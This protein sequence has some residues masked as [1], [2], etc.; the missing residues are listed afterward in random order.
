MNKGLVS[1]VGTVKSFWGSNDDIWEFSGQTA[2]MREFGI[3]YGPN[4]LDRNPLRDWIGQSNYDGLVIDG[5]ANVEGLMALLVDGFWENEDDEVFTLPFGLQGILSFLVTIRDEVYCYFMQ[6]GPTEIPTNIRLSMIGYD[7]Y[8][9]DQIFAHAPLDVSG[10]NS[11]GKLRVDTNGMTI[12]NDEL[13]ANMERREFVAFF[14]PN[15]PDQIFRIGRYVPGEESDDGAPYYADATNQFV[16]QLFT[17]QV[18][19]TGSVNREVFH[20][21]FNVETATSIKRLLTEEEN[22]ALWGQDGPAAYMRGLAMGDSA[23]RNPWFNAL[24]ISNSE[25]VR[26]GRITSGGEFTGSLDERGVDTFGGNIYFPEILSDD[27]V[28]FITIRVLKKFGDDLDDHDETGFWT[29]RRIVDPFDMDRDGNYIMERNFQIVGDRF[30]T[31][32]M[33][34]NQ[35]EQKT[36]GI[37]RPEYYNIIL[38]GLQEATLPEY[39]DVMVFMEPTGQEVFKT[40]LANINRNQELAAVIS[41]KILTP[42]SRNVFTTQ[43]AQRVVV[44]GRIST[45]SNAQYAG[46]FEVHDPETFKRYWRQPIGDIGCNLV[47]I[48]ERRYG[49]WAPAWT[50]IAGDLGGQLKGTVIRSRY[51]FEDEATKVL[52]QRGINPIAFTSDEGL[53]ILSHKN[54]QDPNFT[55]D[56][57]WLGHSLSFQL[58]KREIRDNV[59]RPQVMKPIN[60]YWMGMRQTQVDNI[61]SRRTGGS[62]P[63][64]SH[65]SCDIF[66]QNNAHTKAQRNFVIKVEVRVYTFSETVLLVLENIPQT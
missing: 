66:G 50:N 3:T 22:I 21:I 15:Q 46:E 48:I 17:S 9:Y 38:E 24:T 64:W 44:N 32:V 36:G 5:E 12:S 47:R 7:K 60:E 42:N 41:P 40:D 34:M 39:D 27:D 53:M 62:N 63:I 65:A 52:D 10:W 30:T 51:Q 56:W 37:W 59:M 26:P 49:G 19:L 6:K 35:L 29:H 45:T 61:L 2:I 28:A 18:P 14:R 20:K 33:T 11:E 1:P 23:P 58:V 25:E 8:R 31:L 16:T 57:S 13:L 4:D 55:S 43:L 54:T